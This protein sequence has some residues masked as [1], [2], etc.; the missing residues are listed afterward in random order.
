M[1]QIAGQSPSPVL[2]GFP[3]KGSRRKYQTLWSAQPNAL[4]PTHFTDSASV[5]GAGTEFFFFIERS[6]YPKDATFVMFREDQ[7]VISH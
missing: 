2:Y 7:D 3:T 5:L 1:V 6:H 4:P